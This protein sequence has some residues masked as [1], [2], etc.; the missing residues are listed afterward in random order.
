MQQ[1]VWAVDLDLNYSDTQAM[2]ALMKFVTGGKMD[3]V[4]HYYD[5][6]PPRKEEKKS[7]RRRV[8]EEDEVKFGG[9][10][11]FVSEE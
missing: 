1:E 7:R 8:K 9:F 4:T 3:P 11:H 5:I 10:F 2:F 6:P